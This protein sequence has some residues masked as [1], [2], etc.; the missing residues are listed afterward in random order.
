MMAW[1]DFSDK[2]YV[3]L[4]LL[5]S[6]VLALVTACGHN[7]VSPL[8]FTPTPSPNRITWSRIK[9]AGEIQTKDRG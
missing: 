2:N 3:F 8:E 5:L 7:P 6:A 9:P 4:C 1:R